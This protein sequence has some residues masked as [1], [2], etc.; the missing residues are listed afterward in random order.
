MQ[1]GM[2]EIAVNVIVHY[3]ASASVVFLCSFIMVLI[4]VFILHLLRKARGCCMHVFSSISIIAKCKVVLH[5]MMYGF[6]RYAHAR[7]QA[8]AKK[9]FFISQRCILLFY[10]IFLRCI[11]LLTG[12]KPEVSWISGCQSWNKVW[13]AYTRIF[14]KTKLTFLISL[15]VVLATF[16][17]WVSGINIPVLKFHT[18]HRT[19]FVLSILFISAKCLRHS[20][21]NK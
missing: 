21:L 1:A 17:T 11:S 8:R 20:S 12:S 5:C 14:S 6:R 7:V 16:G 10:N 13:K 4:R 3:K 9:L 15:I 19:C 2:H 18:V